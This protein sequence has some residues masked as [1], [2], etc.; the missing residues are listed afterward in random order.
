MQAVF[1]VWK[2]Q[3][4]GSIRALYF[5]E[6]NLGLSPGEQNVNINKQCNQPNN[7]YLFIIVWVT[8]IPGSEDFIIKRIIE[9]TKE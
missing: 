1:V 2:L 9:K 3:L 7:Y 5:K 6:R 8:W 4:E